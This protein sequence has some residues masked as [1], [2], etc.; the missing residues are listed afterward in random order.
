MPASPTKVLI[1]EDE[2][3]VAID[4][5]RRLLK[6]GYQVSA[7]AATGEQALRSIEQNSPDLIL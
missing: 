2:S 5:E 1:V 6:D 7:T 4:L 3:I